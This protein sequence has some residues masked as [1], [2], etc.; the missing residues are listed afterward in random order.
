[1]KR[2]HTAKDPDEIHNL[3]NEERYQGKKGEL[4]K[5][6]FQWLE[7]VGD[8]GEIPEMEMVVE[9]WW[10]GKD[11]PPLTQEPK[12]KK[13]KEGVV[14]TCDTKGASIGYRIFNGPP[15][16]TTIARA[17]HTWGFYW[18]FSDGNK[19]TIEVPKPWAVYTG[20]TIPL[21]KGQ[22]IQVNAHRI[23][24]RPTEITYKFN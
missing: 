1:M 15:T 4:N 14:L 10:K 17:I 11:T 6:L 7:E 19:K 13:T 2:Y 21:K 20:G 23:G 5:V 22:T 9:Q 24:Y 12:I 16:D 18:L 8:M 3:A